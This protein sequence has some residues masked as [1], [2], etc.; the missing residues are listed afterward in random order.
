[1]AKKQSGTNN[2]KNKKKRAVRDLKVKTAKARM[3]RGGMARRF[4]S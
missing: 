3:I 4:I 2:G 1:M